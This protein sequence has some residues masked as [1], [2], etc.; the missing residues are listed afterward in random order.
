M[1]RLSL[2]PLAAAIGVAAL[3]AGAGPTP[4]AKPAQA[5]APRPP[6]LALEVKRTK[7]DNGL[8][9][10]MLVDHAS[11]TVAIDVVYDVGSRSELRGRTGFAHLFEHMMF[12][13]SANVPRGDHFKLLTAH[14]GTMNGTTNADRTSYYEV[15][16]SNEL[17]LGLW[18]EA[19]RMKS[20]DVSE[21]NFENQRAV[22]KEEYRMR[23]ANAA[24][25]P[26]EIRLQELVY[27]GYWPY[28]HPLIGTMR[29]LDGAE[30]SWVREFHSHWYA[31]NNAVLSV[32]GDFDDA[33]C[34]AL[35]RRWFGDAAPAPEPKVDLPPA[36]EQAA[37]RHEVVEDS[38]A[39]L[40]AVMLGWL[41]P[42]SG[43][44]DHDAL[45]MAA[46]LLA[47]GESSR[48]HRVLVRERSLAVD[49][50]AET[51]GHRGPDMFEIVVKLSDGA[52]IADAEHVLEAQV[53]DVARLGPSDAEMKK[54]RTR[55]S[56]S[57]VLGL[58][59]NF[60]KAKR[61]ATFELDRGDARLLNTEPDR[62]LAVTKDDIQRV[63]A[64]YLTTSRRSTIEV[65]P[66]AQD[67]P[68]DKAG[69]KPQDKAG[70]KP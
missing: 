47:D 3:P 57:F 34:L 7:L 55:V 54:L 68:Q 56:A 20:L 65:K 45:A 5:E 32:A 21:K 1:R 24:Y 28:E 35:V 16:P 36:P 44:P 46:R 13:G 48:L 31:P 67:R 49:V 9:V 41:V 12:Q 33:E 61:L 58:E 62:L 27:R 69:D 39:K 38:H 26:A 23:V 64:K 50:E 52:R 2:V 60:A 42:P 37:P 53:A 10:V 22:V 4:K 40:P 63:V 15:L 29:D 70:D 11:P 19:D 18:L 8:R 6:V 43:D 30:L 17:A 14:G 66:G 25:A 59:S 51:T